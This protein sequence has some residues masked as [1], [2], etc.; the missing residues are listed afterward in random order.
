MI[1]S[2]A[3]SPAREVMF[4]RPLAEE[5][6]G[7]DVGLR[8]REVRK[9]R[10]RTLRDVAN[11]AGITEGFLS[12][13]ERGKSNASVAVLRRI[14]VTLGV[15]FGDL[16]KQDSGQ[17]L[18]VL[19]ATSWPALGFGIL[20]RKYQLH[21]SPDREFDALICDFEPGGSTGTELYTHGDSDELLLVLVGSATLT[22]GEEVV[23]LGPDDSTVYRSSVPHRLVADRYTGARVLFITSPPSF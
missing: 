20:G 6:E 14:A 7:I 16:F 2:N 18:R 4:S 22:V 17:G 23:S 8:L 15:S 3:E 19:S 13:V 10:R 5:G 12:Q 11:A 21:P 9:A 1:A